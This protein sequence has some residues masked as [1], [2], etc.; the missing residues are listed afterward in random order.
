MMPVAAV[1]VAGANGPCKDVVAASG[2]A[3][4]YWCPC[5]DYEGLRD[6]ASQP[7]ISLQLNPE[8][9][10]QC[11]I[12]LSAATPLVTATSCQPFLQLQTV[13]PPPLHSRISPAGLPPLSCPSSRRFSE[14]SGDS[15]PFFF[16]VAPPSLRFPHLSAHHHHH[17]H[18]HTVYPHDNQ[19][20]HSCLFLFHYFYEIFSCEFFWILP[21]ILHTSSRLFFFPS[22]WSPPFRPHDHCTQVI[23][24][25]F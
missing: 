9:P 1:V 15:A 11:K 6:P 22:T 24:F 10:L 23:S 13:T 12:C 18:H 17:H 14:K 2:E 5:K 3:G 19:A 21:V 25:F 4:A 16:F 20:S 7:A 8:S